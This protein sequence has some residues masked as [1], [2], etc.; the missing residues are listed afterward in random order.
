MWF[1]THGWLNICVNNPNFTKTP[2]VHSHLLLNVHYFLNRLLHSQY[3]DCF[4]Q[5][6][7]GSLWPV[8]IRPTLFPTYTILCESNN[9]F[10][11]LSSKTKVICKAILWTLIYWVNTSALIRLIPLS[12][13]TSYIH[14]NLTKFIIDRSISNIDFSPYSK[15]T[16]HTCIVTK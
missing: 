8:I 10:K 2:S 3:D 15:T 5:F 6:L 14:Y 13:P 16:Q 1:G 4:R 7:L 12:N 9:S 11:C